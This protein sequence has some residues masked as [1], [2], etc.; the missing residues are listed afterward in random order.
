MSLI[1][2]GIEIE[3]VDSGEVLALISLPCVNTII[4]GIERQCAKLTKL[5]D[6]LY[7]RAISTTEVIV[8]VN[9]VIIVG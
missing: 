6:G 2:L 3:R 8:A 9:H 4:V 7:L 1:T 5:D